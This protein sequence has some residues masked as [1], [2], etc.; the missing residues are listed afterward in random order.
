MKSRPTLIAVDQLENLIFIVRGQRVMLDSDLA[1]VYGVSTKALNQAVKRNAAR[2]PHDFAF[3]LTRAEFASLGAQCAMSNQSQFVT[4]SQKHRDPRFPPCAF[5]EHGAIMAATILN[6][7]RAVA[8]SI[9]VVRACIKMRQVLVAN[10]A[11]AD[12]LAEW[13]RKL[14]KR[15]DTHERA[16]VKILQQVR[17]L[18][19]TPP[20]DPGPPRKQIGFHVKERNAKYVVMNKTDGELKKRERK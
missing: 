4:G 10:R 14:T 18:M 15:L 19:A 17:Q 12:K 7:D 20:P 6:S 13:E 2:F 8:M 11:L 16:I 9:Y 1:R 3:R 5:T